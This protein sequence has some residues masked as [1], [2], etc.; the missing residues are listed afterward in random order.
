M[1]PARDPALE[2]LVALREL[3]ALLDGWEPQLIDVARS[4]GASWAELAPALGV[5]S[6]QAAERR[7]LRLRRTDADIPGATQ[8][9][10]VQAE[11]DRRAGDRAVTAW[12]REHGADLRQLAGQVSALSDLGPV[13]QP[14]LERLHEALGTDDPAALI[15]LLA[16]AHE[17]LPEAHEGLADRVAGVT[18]DTD[19]ARHDGE[20]ARRRP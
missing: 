9:Q 18:R 15:P 10:R 20:Q 6:R 12:A 8:D 5:A 3:R 2:A 1:A 14:D 11:R 7:Y 19:Q 16:A 4:A 17:H 13:A